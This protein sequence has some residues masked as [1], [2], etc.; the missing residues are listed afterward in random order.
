MFSQ[1][2]KIGLPWIYPEYEQDDLTNVQR[3][4][5]KNVTEPWRQP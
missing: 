2:D 5:L 1:F 4:A 3:A